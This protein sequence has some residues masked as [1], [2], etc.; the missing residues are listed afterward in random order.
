MNK[1][2][3]WE[4]AFGE[5]SRD[6]IVE[7]EDIL[8]VQFPEEYTR[9]VMEYD[10]ATVSPNVF[11]VQGKERVFGGLLSFTHE[12]EGENIIEVYEAIK[13]RLPSM[14]FPI[15]SDPAGNYIC[16]DYRNGEKPKII[17]WEHEQA[18]AHEDISDEDFKNGKLSEMQEQAIFFVANSFSEFIGKLHHYEE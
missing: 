1:D 13:D 9:I 6:L 15:A 2:V 12:V 14:V 16:F 5:V 18:V 3:I 17:F 10:G 11:N 8:N 4:L 7:V